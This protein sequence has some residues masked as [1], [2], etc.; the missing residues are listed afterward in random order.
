MLSI[1]SKFVEASFD[2]FR[3]LPNNLSIFEG[4]ATEE[5]VGASVFWTWTG[6]GFSTDTG[7][8]TFLGVT[9]GG[10]RLLGGFNCDLVKVAPEV[11]AKTEEK[12]AAEDEVEE[13]VEETRLVTF[14]VGCVTVVVV[15]LGL[16]K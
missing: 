10:R 6:F 4:E 2:G 7:W 14:E 9:L 11:V 5:L 15:T 8:S 16:L 12:L 3:F 1:D 13:V